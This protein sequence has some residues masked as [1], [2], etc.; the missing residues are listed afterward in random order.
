[1]NSVSI[2]YKLW[3]MPTGLLDPGEDVGE[4]AVRELKEET[5]LDGKLERILSIRQAH[6]EGR[7]SDLFFVCKLRLDDLNQ[8]PKLQK[9]EIL[10]L[11]WMNPTEYSEQELWRESPVYQELNASIM[12]AA[13]HDTAGMVQVTLP[14][15]FREGTNSLFMS[16]HD[17]E[18]CL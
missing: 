18:P 13:Q 6:S 3:K 12:R 17:R 15:G 2:A 9:E 7:A 11:Q 5:G 8:T 10:E 16:A 14:V 4:A 1:V